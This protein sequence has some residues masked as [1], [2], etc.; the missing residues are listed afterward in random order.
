MKLKKDNR[1]LLP[2]VVFAVIAATLVAATAQTPADTDN[3]RKSDYIF[4]EALRRN[5]L[6]DKDAYYML[7]NR[8]AELDPE[9]TSLGTDLGFYEILLFGKDSD[10]VADGLEK[11]KRHFEK[12]PGEFFSTLSY[13]TVLTKLGRFDEAIEVWTTLDSIYPTKN[14]VAL[15]LAEALSSSRD[16]TNILKAIE[17]YD[18]LEK[19]MGKSQML[20][21]SKITSY[22]AI[23][24]TTNAVAQMD[25]L[26]A[27]APFD[28][29]T[30]IMAGDLQMALQRPDSAIVYFDRACEVD[31]TSGPAFYKRASYYQAMGDSA[32]YD[33]EILSTLTKDNLDVDVKMELLRV[34]LSE[35]YNDSTR[36]PVIEDVFTKII[37]RHPHEVGLHELYASYLVAIKD[38]Q[39]AA[40]QQSYALD[41][42]PSNVD[43]WKGLY[44]L[45]VSARDIN[46]QI[47][48]G[49]T[50][51]RYFPDDPEINWYTSMSYLQDKRYGD[52]LKM[53]KKAAQLAFEQDSTNT[54]LLSDINCS[55][56]D[57]YYQDNNTDSAFFYYNKSLEYNPDNMLALNNCAY[58]LACQN[59]D[60]D[61][62][63]EMSSRTIADQP[64]SPTA[65]D[66]YAWVLFKKRDYKTAKE[67]IDRAIELS[68]EPSEELFHH[69]GDI[70]FMEGDPAK[71]LEFWEKAFKLDPDNELLKRK[72][73]NK[74][75]YYE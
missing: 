44:S 67:F 40:E 66:T 34:Y 52:A 21:G 24:D 37:D 4:M 58:Y 72:I 10:M 22:M 17:I 69:A 75:F 23:G 5:A 41:I 42:D 18:R 74:T 39:K 60:L 9:E 25:S 1:L 20:T 43:S 70:Y 71:A 61:R 46:G 50:A 48:A 59:R 16:T 56:G 35:V 7:L 28:L 15:N 47:K 30:L 38:F 62:A 65:L 14:E 55:I 32:R 45:Y 8:A 2:I 64:D 68:P 3:K 12:A 63:E 11:M 49:E 26:V 29:S 31:S 27:Y 53:A 33:S 57:A 36:R 6:G 19:I 54:R 51:L 73:K 13:G